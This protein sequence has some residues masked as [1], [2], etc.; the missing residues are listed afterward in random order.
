[1]R[2]RPDEGGTSLLG[3][4]GSALQGI[5][6]SLDM[7]SIASYPAAASDVHTGKP[8]AMLNKLEAAKCLSGEGKNWFIQ[9]TDPFHDTA[10]KASGYP[11]TNCASSIVQ[12]VKQSQEFGVPDTE[13]FDGNWDCNIVLWPNPIPFTGVL[14]TENYGSFYQLPSGSGTTPYMVGG[15]TALCAPSGAQTYGSSSAVNVDQLALGLPPQYVVGEHRVV[16]MGMEVVNTTSQLNVQGQ[17]T[18]YRQAA[19]PPTTKRTTT[20]SNAGATITGTYDTY[21]MPQPP[22]TL[23]QAQ[24]LAGSQT[25]K[26]KDGAYCVATM[27]SFENPAT[28]PSPC[29]IVVAT[30][31]EGTFGVS[32]EVIGNTPIEFSPAEGVNT[33]VPIRQPLSPYNMAGCYMT[34]L[35]PG[36]TLQVTVKYYIERFPTPTDQDLVVLA[37]PSAPFDA[38]AL[39]M[40]QRSMVHLPVGVPQ[41]ENP[42]GEWFRDVVKSVTRYTTPIFRGLSSVNPIFGAAAKLSKEINKQVGGGQG[43]KKKP[44]PPIKKRVPPPVPPKRLKA[45]PS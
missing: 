31:E 4:K 30:G 41:G 5:S 1:M 15:V 33:Y 2:S 39:E 29:S 40:Y 21:K 34:G 25:W 26:A 24:L 9:A 8:S 42:L 17:A 12:T 18:V 44:P 45:K 7:E 28:V 37:Q 6:P 43:K 11:D 20:Y 3:V 32:D 35:S 23:A 38:C 14:L 10:F 27:N 16:G 36:T 22:G 19:P 13:A